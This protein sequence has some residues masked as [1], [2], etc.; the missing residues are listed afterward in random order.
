MPSPF[1]RSLL[2]AVAVVCA[3]VFL[4]AQGV[5]DQARGRAHVMLQQVKKDLQE[6]Y[7]DSTFGGVDL[8]A[9]YRA[10]DSA[11][12]QTGTVQELFGTIAQFVLDLKDSHTNFLPPSRAASVNYGW[13]WTIIGDQCFVN[14]VQKDSDAEKKGLAIGDRVLSIDGILPNRQTTHLIRY[15]YGSLNPRPGMHLAVVKPDGTQLTMDAMA[16]VTPEQ[17]VFDYN[18]FTDIGRLIIEYDRS[19]NARRHWWRSFGDSVLVWHFVQFLGGDEGIDEMMDRARH[20]KTLILDL[21]NNGGGAETAIQQLIGHFY[22]HDVRIA[23][24]RERGSTHPLLARPKNRH[25]FT[26]NL[27]ILINSRSASASEITSRF[28][29][30]EGRATLVGDRSAGAVMGAITTSHAA[31]F[32]KFLEYGLQV[33]VEDLIMP[34]EGRLENVGVTP[35]FIVL[36]T[37]AD[38]AAKRDPQMAKALA[39]AGIQMDPVAAGKIYQGGNH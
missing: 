10:A 4:P 23:T 16:K 1:D 28:L 32:S 8:E 17:R 30:L 5:D 38:L 21:R 27:I 25:P 39:L 13:G 26:G 12:D 36:P 18:S 15:L 37:G 19:I 34:D 29:Q 24:T 3:P 22:E 20:H 35:E 7:Y 2:A 31:G 9:R 14:F 6:Y 11:L 33:T